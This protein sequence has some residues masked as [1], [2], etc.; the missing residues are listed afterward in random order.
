MNKGDITVLFPELSR[1]WHPIKNGDLKFCDMT[2]SS[3]RKVWWICDKGH[4]WEAR[5]SDRTR[6]HG[7]PY[8]SGRKALSGINDLQTLFPVIAAE[9]NYQ[10]NQGIAPD[11]VTAKSK[12]KVWWMCSKGHEW[13]STIKNR[14]LH[15]STCPYCA[16]IIAIPGENDIAT[17]FPNLMKEWNYER[18][19][20]IS[21][22]HLLQYSNRKVWWK[23]F[24]GHEWEDTVTHRTQGRG[25][26]ICNKQN[27]TSF[28]EQAIS[29]YVRR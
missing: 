12:K 23:G 8:C 9:W 22:N 3:G 7:C 17:L 21:P 1:E 18:N 20:E 11:C 5:I 15:E 28:P 29:Y 4:E 27:R 26:P 10:R 13:E 6:N 14:T 25:C 2:P 16:G 19:K 24:C